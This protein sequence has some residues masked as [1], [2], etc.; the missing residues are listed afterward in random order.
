MT[1]RTIVVPSPD[2][3]KDDLERTVAA[4][5][6]NPEMIRALHGAI[7]EI[8]ACVAGAGLPGARVALWHA[9]ETARDIL[10]GTPSGGR[11]RWPA[12][13]WAT[14]IGRLIFYA[15]WTVEGEG[16]L[17]YQRDVAER[18]GVSI[19]RVA[20]IQATGELDYLDD[21]DAGHANQDRRR[22]PVAMLGDYL[23]RTGREV[24]GRED[25]ASE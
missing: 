18:L 14:P 19:S 4:R 2:A 9:Y 12:G 22:T 15:F 7:D 17:L 13:F 8:V 25:V 21:P 20:Q 3:V 11:T 6:A 24:T 16:Y 23:V 10:N 5:L 1:G